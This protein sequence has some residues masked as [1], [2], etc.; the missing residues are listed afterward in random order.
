MMRPAISSQMSRKSRASLIILIVLAFLLMAAV[1][2]L[3]MMMPDENPLPAE[4]EPALPVAE[5][6]AGFECDPDEA[7]RLYP[8]S[9]G[10]YSVSGSRIARLDLQGEELFSVDIDYEAPMVI[11]AEKT[12]L[13]ADRGGYGFVVLDTD[14][15]I[16]RDRSEGRISGAAIG[17]D[18]HLAIIH[19]TSASTGV[20]SVYAPAGAGH[21]YDCLF[22]ES[23]FILSV[24]FSPFQDAFDVVLLNTDAS[25][26]Q[27][28]VKRFA[29]DGDAVG[30]RLPELQGL[31]PLLVYNGS[32]QLILC[33]SQQVTALTY[34]QE[35]EVWQRQFHQVRSVLSGD[36]YILAIA[37]PEMDGRYE[38]SRIDDQGQ[39]RTLL[40]TDS[41]PAQMLDSGTVIAVA[42][43][44]TLTLLTN[45][46]GE[47]IAQWPM[48]S[49]IIRM[50]L[51]GQEALIVVT[52]TEVR[53]FDLN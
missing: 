26:A 49:D 33:G 17:R 38:I 53:R 9:D 22:P 41:A 34:E 2:V 1:V 40:Q 18:N 50:N 31:A 6:M 19:E 15:E 24:V 27:L 5:E 25:E 8:F 44:N 42:T 3:V 46:S 32:G 21:L 36:G 39:S 20:V 28:I 52:R 12:F 35:D 7:Q 47:T 45:D 16:Y 43:G 14:G 37:A 13:V 10:L 4:T 30:Q 23:G 11:Q 48:A 29:L 51:V